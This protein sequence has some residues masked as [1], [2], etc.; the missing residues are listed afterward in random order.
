MG[1]ELEDFGND[2]CKHMSNI[3]KEYSQELDGPILLMVDEVLPLAPE[4]ES[5]ET[6]V[7][8]WT[9]LELS[10]K[11]DLLMAVSPAPLVGNPSTSSSQLIPP[12]HS[13]MFSH[14]LLEGHRNFAQLHRLLSCLKHHNKV[15]KSEKN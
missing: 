5:G 9:S 4:K 15:L 7:Y 11:V 10:P 1:G 2:S 8:D 12:S 13:T 14:Q 3:I 6:L